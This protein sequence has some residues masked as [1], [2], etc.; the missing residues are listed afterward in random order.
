ML[1]H[2]Q[3]YTQPF[4][5]VLVATFLCLCAPLAFAK[6]PKAASA[7]QVTL[8]PSHP[9]KGKMAGWRLF[10]SDKKYHFDAA[11]AKQ[12]GLLQGSPEQLA[13]S[14]AA[15]LVRGDKKYIKLLSPK[16]AP[17][18]RKLHAT[19]TFKGLGKVA[20]HRFFLSASIG[21][22]A[23]VSGGKLAGMATLFGKI[24]GP[25]QMLV[26]VEG[27]SSRFDHF[28]LAEKVNGKWYVKGFVSKLC[29]WLDSYAKS[30]LKSAKP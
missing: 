4:A 24:F 27:P 22:K 12:I 2:L 15:S 28:I 30:V 20:F 8:P 11:K 6:V 23:A 19:S 16:M 26:L 21:Q 7:A 17:K 10:K 5:L 3:K 14:F 13:I 29:T 1:R 9:G 18:L 25:Y